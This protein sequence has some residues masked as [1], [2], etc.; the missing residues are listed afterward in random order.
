MVGLEVDFSTL[1]ATIPAWFNQAQRDTIRDL[2]RQPWPQNGRLAAYRRKWF[3][4]IIDYY[5]G[6][7]TK[8]IFVRLPRGPVV[9]PDN[10]VRKMSSSIREFGGRPNLFL[11]N[12]HAFDSLEHPEFFKDAEHLNRAG[13]T[14]LSL[15][16]A[17]E[18]ARILDSP[19]RAK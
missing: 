13:V 11:L 2:V 18:V 14:R 6:S 12:E 5:R 4:R 7:R 3:G 10:L 9:R 15:M 1:K 8:V 19:R 17:D 16:L